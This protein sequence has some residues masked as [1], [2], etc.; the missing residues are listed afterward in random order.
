M[1]QISSFRWDLPRSRSSCITLVARRDD[2]RGG[3]GT[4][5]GATARL[6]GGCALGP[7][8]DDGAARPRC[9]LSRHHGRRVVLR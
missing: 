8:T 7:C 2:A 1:I 3:H 9:R 4:L 6:C 5:A